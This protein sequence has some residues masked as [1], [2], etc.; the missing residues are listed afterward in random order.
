MF[1]FLLN[2]SLVSR[3]DI[4]YFEAKNGFYPTNTP[5]APIQNI[6]HVRGTWRTLLKHPPKVGNFSKND[7]FTMFGAHSWINS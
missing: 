2:F 7:F 4:I 3:H 6:R 1:F 5:K